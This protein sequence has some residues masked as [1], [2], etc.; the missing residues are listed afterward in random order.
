MG[1]GELFEPPRMP[2]SNLRWTSIPSSENND[3]PSRIIL[4][5]PECV[6]ANESLCLKGSTYY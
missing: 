4:Q 5:K 2:R 3:T 6:R 1:A